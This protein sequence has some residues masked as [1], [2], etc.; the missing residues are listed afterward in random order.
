M[1]LQRRP[2]PYGSVVRVKV[3]EL[4]SMQIDPAKIRSPRVRN[5]VTA[6]LDQA[7]IGLGLEIRPEWQEEYRRNKV[8]VRKPL[9]HRILLL[10]ISSVNAFAFT[11]D[12]CPTIAITVGVP[13][14]TRALFVAALADDAVL[15]DLRDVHYL[16]TPYKSLTQCDWVRLAD[17]L[18]AFSVEKF[19]A[20]AQSAPRL[21][22]TADHSGRGDLAII[23]SMQAWSFIVFHELGHHAMLHV[24][25]PE[26]GPPGLAHAEIEDMGPRSISSTKPSD[27]TI[28]QSSADAQLSEAL[29]LG[30]ANE[31]EADRYATAT[32]YKSLFRSHPGAV[33]KS[34]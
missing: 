31:L 3:S 22:Q 5:E 7:R 30:H 8:T 28:M 29:L 23:L 17:L 32:Q 9:V 16:R 15:N 19:E 26:P 4:L 20:W 24:R 34:A 14:I 2:I 25:A 13:L 10:D 27:G 21:P 12:G 18:I 6:L 33:S 1:I 11:T